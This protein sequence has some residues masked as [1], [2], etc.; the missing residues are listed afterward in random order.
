M[1]KGVVLIVLSFVDVDRRTESLRRSGPR[2]RRE[3]LRRD[4]RE[5]HVP[6]IAG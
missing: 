1:G 2:K 4:V 3:R 5:E 6:R